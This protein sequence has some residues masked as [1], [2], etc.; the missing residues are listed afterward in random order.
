MRE[1]AILHEKD[2]YFKKN[3]PT[4]VRAL[5]RGKGCPFVCYSSKDP[6]TND[7]VIK[8]YVGEHRCAR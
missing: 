8:T 3:D 6:K 7:F 2:V 4:R 1:Y 5:C